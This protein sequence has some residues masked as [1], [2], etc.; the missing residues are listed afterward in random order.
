MET[1]RS[2][3]APATGKPG[4]WQ[5][6]KKDV[7]GNTLMIVGAAMIP[8][9]GAVGLGVDVAQWVLWKRQ[10]SSA[11]DLAALAGAH[12]VVEKKSANQAARRSLALNNL[13][14][15]TIDAVE[16]APTKGKYAGDATAVR[17]QL[18]ASQSL[19]FSGIFM[20][21]PMS[22]TVSATAQSVREVPNCM[23]ALDSTETTSIS[24]SG[25]ARVEMN[26]AMH[27]NGSGTQS[28]VADGDWVA[29]AALS[30]NG[31]VSG[32][33][34]D[35]E[36]TRVN[37]GAGILADPLASLG[38]PATTVACSGAS[39]YTQK[40]NTTGSIGPGCYTGLSV[41]GSLTL[42]PGT[43]IIDGGDVSIGAKGALKGSGVTLV[44][45]NSNPTSTAIGKF[46]ANGTSLVQLSA[47]NTGTYAGIIMYQDRRAEPSN[48]T[49]FFVTGN[50]GTDNA[51]NTVNSFYEGTIYTPKTY[52][53]FSGNSSILTPCMQVVAM[54]IE[55]QGNTSV[56]NTCPPGSGSKAYGG[57][58]GVR[59]VE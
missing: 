4:F 20:T 37:N 26:C 49:N 1:Q 42:T 41:Q 57:K 9:I 51:G 48:Q 44:F 24:V 39:F 11:T 43:Y 32:K 55:F 47:P 53:Q 21:G 29:V 19:P 45:T 18:T 50:S 36:K 27:S 28:L 46:T 22:I 2:P 13:R 35:S 14:G 59:L 12:A 25:S 7:R 33:S 58:G 40:S 23:I 16:N 5:R 10:L 34:F 52:T 3:H 31:S 17:V 38:T 56:N 30:A 15:F 6:L 8:M 54:R